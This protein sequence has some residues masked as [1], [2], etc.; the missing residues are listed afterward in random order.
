MAG[1]MY[2]TDLS[3]WDDATYSLRHTPLPLPPAPVQLVYMFFFPK[4]TRATLEA[5][6]AE[7]VERID[8]DMALEYQVRRT[9]RRGRVG[10]VL[11]L[12]VGGS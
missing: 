10:L 8:T 3:L 12:V 2:T 7:H 5:R 11:G 1:H 6:L 9:R 4:I